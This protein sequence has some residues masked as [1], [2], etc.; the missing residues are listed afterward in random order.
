MVNNLKI[1]PWAR[2]YGELQDKIRGGFTVQRSLEEIISYMEDKFR[3]YEVFEHQ[4]RRITRELM[5]LGYTLDEITKGINAYLLQL[6]PMSSD[7]RKQEEVVQRERSYRVLDD[8]E[9]RYIG[10]D[11]YGYLYLL[12][13]MGLISSRETENIIS[14]ILENKV[15][16][17][18][19]EQMQSIML[20]MVLNT[21]YNENQ[22]SGEEEEKNEENNKFWH[23]FRKKRLH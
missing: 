19:G 12:R 3:P 10:R 2:L 9:K 5:E 20:D 16:V 7:I 13:E 22:S 6:E 21:D 15:E 17:E 4:M 1:D 23:N 8:S 14:Y 18:N 11:A